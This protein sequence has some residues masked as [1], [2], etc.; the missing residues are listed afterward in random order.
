MRYVYCHPLFDE[1]KCAHRFSYDLQKTFEKE[2][3]PFE[4]FDYHGTGEAEGR[5]EDVSL[6]SLRAD[7][8]A[9]INGE[10][11]CLIG[12]RFGATLALNYAAANPYAVKKLVLLEPFVD[13][14]VYVDYLYRKQHIKDLMTGEPADKLRENGFVNIEGYK[15]SILFLDQIKNINSSAVP[16][17]CPVLIV[18]ISNNSKIEPE[19]MALKEQLEHSEIE[20]INM[21]IF[22]ERIPIS[23]YSDL[24][25]TI[26]RW[27]K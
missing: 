24:T 26:L 15:T 17:E 10:E 14:A 19:I 23:D 13:G 12:L 21:P 18:Q 27:C 16:P 20:F 5:F 11:I 2:P 6:D 25:D 8:E 3:L 7:V 9:Q 4:R 22:W 1:R